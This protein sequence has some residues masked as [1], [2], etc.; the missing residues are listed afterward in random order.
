MARAVRLALDLGHP[1]KDRASILRWRWES[2]GALLTSDLRLAAKGQPSW[3][4]I[5]VVEG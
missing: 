3:P 5:R 2:A 4:K 1:L